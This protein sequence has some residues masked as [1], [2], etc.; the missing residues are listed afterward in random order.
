[1]SSEFQ[2]SKASELLRSGMLY[3]PEHLTSTLLSIESIDNIQYPCE[4]SLKDGRKLQKVLL[5]LYPE[6]DILSHIACARDFYFINDVLEI[7]PSRRTLSREIRTATANAQEFSNNY[8]PTSLID[9]KGRLLVANG[10]IH[11]ATVDQQGKSVWKLASLQEIS[12]KGIGS[13]Y[14]QGA[15]TY[16]IYAAS[17]TFT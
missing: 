11:F 6:R 12:I 15:P 4:V 9:H 16:F 10:A 7:Y 13:D 2:I 8:A 5:V 3:V 1:M 14:Q 17:R